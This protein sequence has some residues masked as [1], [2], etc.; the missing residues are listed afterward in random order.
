MTIH[1]DS[2]AEQKALI[3]FAIISLGACE[4]LEN[5]ELSFKLFWVS[6]HCSILV[7]FMIYLII[8]NPTNLATTVVYSRQKSLRLNK[9]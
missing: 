3:F 9:P 4:F 5:V 6:S 8:V 2:Q 1:V 7:S